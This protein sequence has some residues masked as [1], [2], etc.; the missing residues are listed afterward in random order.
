MADDFVESLKADWTGQ[1]A[2]ARL[3]QLRRRRWLPHVLLS[4]DILGGAIMAAAGV[5]YALV[6]LRSGDVLFGLSAVAMLVFGLPLVVAAV[7]V[8]WRN[9]SWNDETPEG[10]LRSTVRRL[11]ASERS[12]RLGR[13]GA[14][15]LFALVIAVWAADLAGQV[16]EPWT[17]LA[18]ITLIWALSGALMLVWVRWRLDRIVRER[19]GCEALLQ[20]F[21][22]A[23]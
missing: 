9:L 18:V 14:W 15:T 21:E 10:V 7:R 6:A 5:A 22:Q 16:R 2:E 23:R 4:L 1:A 12:L 11:H 20:Q 13:G 19:A 17:I 8:R 3:D